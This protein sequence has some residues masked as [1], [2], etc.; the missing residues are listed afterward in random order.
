MQPQPIQPSSRILSQA[1]AAACLF[2]VFA[3][4]ARADR[5]G[6]PVIVVN[7]VTGKLGQTQP[8]VLRIGIDVFPDEIVR[9]GAHSAARLVFLDKTVLE[10]GAVSEVRLDRFVYDPNP[11][12]SQV[13]L[14]VTSGVVRFATGLLPSADYVIHTPSATLAV[15]GTVFTID[16]NPNGTSCIYGESGTVIVTGR[17]KGVRV[18]AG[19]SSCV[20]IGGTPSQPTTGASLPG[21]VLQMAALLSEAATNTQFITTPIGMGGGPPVTTST[22]TTC[23]AP[24]P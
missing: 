12:K 5:I 24:P 15:R 4:P 20:P 22:C 11:A 18:K 6:S 7:Q 21:A 3:G 19:E 2:M 16:V 1:I 10:I 14:S 17:E 9:T 8:V 23:T 13:V